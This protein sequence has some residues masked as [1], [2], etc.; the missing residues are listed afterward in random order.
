MRV[1]T[2]LNLTHPGKLMSEAGL[3]RK[4]TTTSA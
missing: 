1:L 3:V 2:F 4:L